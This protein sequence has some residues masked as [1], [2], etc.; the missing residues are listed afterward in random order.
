MA[1]YA[2]LHICKGSENNLHILHLC[3]GLKHAFLA[4]EFYALGYMHALKRGHTSFL[5]QGHA[6]G[7]FRPSLVPRVVSILSAPCALY[8]TGL[9][10]EKQTFHLCQEGK[11]FVKST[12]CFE[13]YALNN[14]KFLEIWSGRSI[15]YSLIHTICM[16]PRRCAYLYSSILQSLCV[17]GL[18]VNKWCLSYISRHVFQTEYFASNDLT[19][20]SSGQQRSDGL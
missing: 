16:C 3:T 17:M 7:K 18:L 6:L 15:F 19:T 5:F 8:L 12:F 10:R 13:A 2:V 1:T 20:A 4:A 9:D 11:D 14:N